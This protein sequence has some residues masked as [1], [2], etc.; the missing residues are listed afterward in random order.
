MI[1]Q[2]KGKHIYMHIIYIHISIYYAIQNCKHKSHWY[3]CLGLWVCVSSKNCCPFFNLTN[4][5]VIMQSF[6]SLPAPT[7][8][9]RFLCNF[10]QVKGEMTSTINHVPSQMAAQTRPRDCYLLYLGAFWAGA[11]WCICVSPKMVIWCNLG[12]WIRIFGIMF[13]PAPSK[14][15]RP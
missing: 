8:F 1:Q 14:G 10:P 11:S 12:N 9:Q 6:I 3:P 2:Q 4:I 13:N 15:C 7:G 5:L